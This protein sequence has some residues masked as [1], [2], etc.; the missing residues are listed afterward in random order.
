MI[1]LKKNKKI[2]N[3][4]FLFLVGVI[5]LGGFLKPIVKPIGIN[6]Q[7]NREAVTL[8]TFNFNSFVNKNY[9]NQFEESLSDQVPLA[10]KMKL[11]QKTIE[12]LSKIT[13]YSFLRKDAYYHLNDKVSLFNNYLTYYPR[14]FDSIRKTHMAKIYNIDH[15]INLLPNIDFYLYYIESDVDINFE[16]NKKLLAYENIKNC[17]G[18]KVKTKA[19]EINSFEDY[20]N[21]FYK[22]D[23]H[24][25]YKGSYKGYTEIVELMTSDDAIKYEKEILLN[26]VMSG[27][28]ANHVGGAHIF[29]EEFAAYQFNL[30]DHDI[31]I[32]N[33]QVNSYGNY[34]NINENNPQNISYGDYYGSDDGLILFDYH[35]KDSENILVIGESY[36]NAIIELL[37]SHFNKTYSVDLRAYEMDLGERFNIQNFVQEKE[38]TKV[39][40]I[41]NVDYYTMSTFNLIY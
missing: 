41:G 3:F 14:E 10:S 7:E 21:Y 18:D 15:A 6:L 36:D 35:Q 12:I 34:K 23:H 31:Y 32:N 27:S 25:N 9:Q 26:S 19:F 11:V 22:T 1:K 37:A 8:P 28:K 5:L 40:L 4:V 30:K 38:I 29:K 13:Y 17:L 33:K 16:T 20:A 24:W 2:T 39:L